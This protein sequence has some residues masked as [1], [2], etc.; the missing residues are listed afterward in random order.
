MSDHLRYRP[1]HR[2]AFLRNSSTAA[3]AAGIGASALA[4]SNPV[5]AAGDELIRVGL[6]GCGGRGT[7]AAVQTLK[8]DS[9]TKLVAMGDVFADRAEASHHRLKN[10]EVG[11]RVDVPPERRFVGFDAY[12]NVIDQCDLV[13]L[14]ATPHFR[15][16][17]LA[18]AVAAGRH[19]FAEK[20]VAVDPAG[21]RSVLRSTAEA[22]AKNL[23][24]VSGLCWRF[25]TGLQETIKRLHDGAIGDIVTMETTRFGGG[26]WIRPRQEGWSDMEYQMRNWYYFTWLSG[27]FNTEQ[28]VHELDQVAWALGDEYPVRCYSTGGR[29]SRTGEQYGHIYDH[30]STVYEYESG[31]R[32]Y[33]T[34][35]HQQGCSNMHH[36]RAFGTQGDCDLLKYTI[37]GENPWQWGQSRT[38]MHQL[39][40]DAMYRALR[41]GQTINNG[42]YMAKSTMMAIIARMSAYT[43]Q[44]LTWE[45]ALN[46]ELE[47]KPGRYAWDAEPPAATVAIPG[48]TEFV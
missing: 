27:D 47:L 18:A 35:R 20:P 26:V 9:Q 48:R 14:C 41:A 21:V 23:M 24:L 16:R 6:V 46:S 36:T 25:E 38:V 44:T 3:V 31:V 29:I 7:G 19:V 4:A 12:Q 22:K 32:L 8:A 17:H 37:N 33:A 43:G 10:S 45:Q 28:F 13:L 5:H 40:H 11:A 2:R 39:E 15:P 42:E 34:A 30:I 1:Q